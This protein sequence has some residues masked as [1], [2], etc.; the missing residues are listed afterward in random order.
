MFAVPKF[1]APRFSQD[2]NELSMAGSP[3]SFQ[4]K[5]QVA[6]ITPEP[7]RPEKFYLQGQVGSQQEAVNEFTPFDPSLQLQMQ[8]FSESVIDPECDS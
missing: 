4:L 5:K 2:E 1:A 8:P 6:N 3:L 7:K